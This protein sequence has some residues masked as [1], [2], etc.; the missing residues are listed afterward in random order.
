[1]KK[2]MVKL[3]AAALCLTLLTGCWQDDGTVPEGD[4][5]PPALPEEEEPEPARAVLPERF[6]LPYMPGQTLDPVTC[7]DGMQQVAASLLYEGLFRLDGALE[8]EPCLCSG[9]TYDAE[10]CRY[11]FVLREGVTFSDGTPLTSNDVR[12]TLERARNSERY[13]S[14]LSGI[15]SISAK[16]D[17]AVTITLTGPDT[18]FPALLDI[19]IVKAK[20]EDDVVPVGT[21]PYVFADGE[22][23]PMLEANPSWWRGGGQ[24]VER[25]YLVEAADQDTLLYRFTSHDVQLIT[26]DLT[27][28]V[29]VSATGS[30]VCLDAGTTVMQYLGCNLARLDS[31][32]LRQALWAGINRE[33]VVSAF[34]SGHGSA[35]QFPVSPLSPLYPKELETPFALDAFSRMLGESGFA[36]EEPLVL[37][38]NAENSF[39]C[40][41]AEYLASSLTEGGLPVEARSL[42]WEEYLAA[43]AA[44]EF[45]LYYG[46]VR[47][48]ANW[49]LTELLG[50]WQPLN[51][52]G[53][54]DERTGE[55]LAA[56]AAAEDRGAAMEALCAYLQEQAP[57]LPLCFKS[58]SVLVQSEVVEGLTPTAAEAFHNLTEC[59]IHLEGEP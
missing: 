41:I 44:G 34:L 15:A 40:S 3:L 51:Y 5:L 9:Y 31:Q 8:P 24:P 19:P 42:P 22:G 35:A 29:P 58:T 6:A 33:Y 56:Y 52:G 37:L 55:L 26:A 7:A 45:D 47:L 32:K 53:W 28:A 14:R 13:R 25:I 17:D 12:S 36:A 2:R 27:G 4:L 38:V 1:M 49:D 54:N 21:G 23:G 10:N 50:A 16:E 20:T 46:E 57:I 43:L 18:G 30:V 59:V 11:R 39:K 48:T